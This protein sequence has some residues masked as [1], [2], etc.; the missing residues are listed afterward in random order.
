MAQ[1]SLGHQEGLYGGHSTSILHE[2]LDPTFLC[3]ASP[4]RPLHFRC[5]QPPFFEGHS[6]TILVDD[7]CARARD[8]GS[9][10]LTGI[11]VFET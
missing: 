11:A 3:S 4:E 7:E 5:S 9:T 1:L 2:Y 10:P 6:S 8:P